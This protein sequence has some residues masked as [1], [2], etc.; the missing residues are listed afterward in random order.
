MQFW[1]A[2]QDLAPSGHN[3]QMSETLEDHLIGVDSNA[4]GRLSELR[5]RFRDTPNFLH[6]VL[7]LCCDE[8]SEVADSATWILKSEIDDGAKLTSDQIEMLTTRLNAITSWQ[9]M[10]HVCQISGRMDV[11]QQQARCLVEWALPLTYHERPFLRAWSLDAVVM[12]ATRFE[13]NKT[14]ADVVLKEALTD[15]AASVRARARKL[16][17]L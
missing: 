16:S 9:A 17:E 15:R 8:R 2:S 1:N 6:D 11:S 4:V 7:R 13:E 3:V 12:L 5:S 14:R 10:L